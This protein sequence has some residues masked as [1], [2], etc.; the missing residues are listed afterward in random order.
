M[1]EPFPLYECRGAARELGRQHGEQARQHIHQ[2]LDFL[3]RTLD[4]TTEQIAAHAAAFQPLIERHTPQLL[5]ELAG[6]AE[7]AAVTPALALAV[8]VRAALGLSHDTG[9]TA[10]AVAAGASADGVL[11]IGQNSDTLP[12]VQPLAYVLR[13]VPDDRPSLLMWTFGGMLGYHGLNA[14][15][16]AHFANDLGGG[17]APRFALPHYPLKRLLLECSDLNQAQACF[18]RLPLASSGNYVLCDGSGAVCDVEATPEGFE[19]LTD[20]GDGIIVHANHFVGSRHASAANH[21]LSAAD[22]FPRQA[23]M[24]TLLDACRGRISRADLEAALRDRAGA[25]AAICRS[26]AP[27]ARPGDDWRSAGVTVASL[28]A[29][30]R[31]GEL[32]IAAGNGQDTLFHTY[33]L[34]A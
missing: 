12:A 25:P 20:D 23:R 22:S 29:E 21:A 19:V 15:G 24:Q 28:I 34:Q 4:V 2:H 6:L 10:F 3:C 13:V 11:R 26:A 7:G 14:H 30:P 33:K 18:E 16:I 17:P 5:E 1:S 32:H 9:C 8:N 27:S 31:S